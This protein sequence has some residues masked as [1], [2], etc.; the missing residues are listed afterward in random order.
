M[1]LVY[2]DAPFFESEASM[3]VFPE[4]E[5]TE[6][7]MRSDVLIRHKKVVVLVSACESTW[8]EA[9]QLIADLRPAACSLVV[10]NHLSHSATWPANWE[11][12]PWATAEEHDFDLSLASLW[13][14]RKITADVVIVLSSPEQV[15]RSDLYSLA[16]CGRTV[17]HLIHSPECDRLHFVS[18]W[19]YQ[20][21][22][23][24]TVFYQALDIAASV[25]LFLVIHCLVTLASLSNKA[26]RT[27]RQRSV[28]ES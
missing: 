19:R 18:G 16:C 23:A 20:Y 22:V 1:P 5:L 27:W 26:K 13:K 11:V 15:R 21:K 10:P 12:I 6:H 24:W 25:V 9:Q 14:F 28:H 3:A 2:D 4:Q 17:V 8:H 7:L